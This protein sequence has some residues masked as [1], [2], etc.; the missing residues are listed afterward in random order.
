M[1]GLQREKGCRKAKLQG[2]IPRGQQKVSPP[3]STVSC[4]AGDRR[5]TASLEP[6]QIYSVASIHWQAIR[7][8]TAPN[9][10]PHARVAR[11]G[12]SGYLVPSQGSPCGED[13]R[14]RK[15][16]DRLSNNCWRSSLVPGQLHFIYKGRKVH[17]RSLF[18]CYATPQRPRRTPLYDQQHIVRTALITGLLIRTRNLEQQY[19]RKRHRRPPQGGHINRRASTVIYKL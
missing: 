1:C 7:S 11:D 8:T 16:T 4:W 13:D 12:L 9:I 18:M 2:H 5:S 6:P 15:R 3:R 17:P 14:S 10:A 19:R